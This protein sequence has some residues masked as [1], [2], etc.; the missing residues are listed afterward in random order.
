MLQGSTPVGMFKLMMTKSGH[1]EP[2]GKIPVKKVL[3]C[4]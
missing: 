2:N 3:E 1:I 4:C